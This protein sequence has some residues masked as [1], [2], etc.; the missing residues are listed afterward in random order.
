[1]CLYAYSASPEIRCE[2][3][4]ILRFRH[5]VDLCE[6]LNQTI[7]PLLSCGC[8]IEHVQSSVLRNSL[9]NTAYILSIFSWSTHFGG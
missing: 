6:Y 8:N 1:M 5:N 7:K 3:D 4:L 9:L 2:A